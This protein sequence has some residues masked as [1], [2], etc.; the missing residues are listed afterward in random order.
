M[1][2]GAL[3][4]AG[5]SGQGQHSPPCLPV[6]VTAAR[7]SP[8]EAT[9]GCNRLDS[10]DAC[11]KSSLAFHVGPAVHKASPRRPAQRWGRTEVRRGRAFGVVCQM[12][13]GWRSPR[14]KCRGLL[15]WN[16][17]NIKRSRVYSMSVKNSHIQII[18]LLPK[19]FAHHFS[20]MPFPFRI[21]TYSSSTRCSFFLYSL[22]RA[23]TMLLK[24]I[25]L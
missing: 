2:V 17:L 13:R 22:T 8:Y 11:G 1:A 9:T 3:R 16:A 7:L 10:T 25:I 6:D 21:Y 5:G 24:K 15:M 20:I 14:D 4:W 23:R 19:R 18:V 12:S